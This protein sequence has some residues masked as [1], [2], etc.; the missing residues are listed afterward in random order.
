M[1]KQL[2]T[3]I[4]SWDPSS[5]QT[6][7]LK[8][9]IRTALF[10]MRFASTNLKNIAEF[11]KQLITLEFGNVLHPTQSLYSTTKMLFERKL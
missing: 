2:L 6:L 11:N 10:F 4:I 1:E 9:A 8:P 7:K 3:M 5:I